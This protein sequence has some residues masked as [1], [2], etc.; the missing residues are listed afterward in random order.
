MLLEVI[1]AA[2]GK[3]KYCVEISEQQIIGDPS[4]LIES[5]VKLTKAGLCIAIDEFVFWRSSFESLVLFEL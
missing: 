5:V 3:K 4:Y 1:Q 2:P